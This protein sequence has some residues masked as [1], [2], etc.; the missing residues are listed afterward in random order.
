ME[1][2]DKDFKCHVASWSLLSGTLRYEHHFAA[3]DSSGF[4][5]YVE[6][7]T[8]DDYILDLWFSKSFSPCTTAQFSPISS[9]YHVIFYADSA[10]PAWL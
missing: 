3:I 2:I 10:R 6:V 1:I 9:S 7:N 8:R 5:Q 4:Q